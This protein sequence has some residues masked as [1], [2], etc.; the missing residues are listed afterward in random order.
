[1][2]IKTPNPINLVGISKLHIEDKIVLMKTTNITMLNTMILT[3]ELQQL[4][5][6]QRKYSK[7]M[8]PRVKSLKDNQSLKNF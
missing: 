8:G 1:M 3:M 4:Q 2:K 5:D 7:M 6:V